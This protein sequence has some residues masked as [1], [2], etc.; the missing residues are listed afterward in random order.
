MVENKE[1]MLIALNKE[2]K[3]ALIQ[4]LNELL[5]LFAFLILVIM[6]SSLLLLAGAVGSISLLI[7]AWVVYAI[8]KKLEKN[9]SYDYDYGMG[10]FESFGGFLANLLMLIGL[11]AVLC[12]SALIFFNP[13][14][15]GEF[16]LWAIIVKLVCTTIDVLL[17][18]EQR[19]INKLA[20]GKLIE[21]ED[22]V[23]RKNLVFDFIALS[24][25]V[26]VYLFRNV[27]F[28]IHFEVVLCTIYAVIMII[29][30]I[31]PLKECAYDLLDKT[32]DEE[33]QLK[34]MRAMAAGDTQYE[35]FRTVRTRTSGQAVYVDILIGFDDN[36]TYAEITKTLETLDKLI[37]EEIPN[38]IVSIVLTK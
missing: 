15:S 34:I 33:I 35:S 8:S 37:T 36:K 19:K 5:N 3:V 31:K 13:V 24:A 17:F 1:N 10:K 38:C 25:I 11:I 4:F 14:G 22:H 27:S 7:Q 12:F 23:I 20:S 6:S 26:I 32:S 28:L 29:R 16:L 2:K 30:L 18:A 9:K 21:A